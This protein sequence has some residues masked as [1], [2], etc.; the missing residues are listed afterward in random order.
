MSINNIY[1]ETIT[2]N[3]SS[4]S[5]SSNNNNDNNNDDDD[6]NNNSN[7]SITLGST[8]DPGFHLIPRLLSSARQ[9]ARRQRTPLRT[10]DYIPQLPH[11]LRN[12]ILPGGRGDSEIS[13]L[14]LP[15]INTTDFH[16]IIT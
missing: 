8:S 9:R 2:F 14:Q 10:A 15:A 6:H 16:Y 1:K 11:L 12:A 7:N 3:S 4:S 13:I 5:S